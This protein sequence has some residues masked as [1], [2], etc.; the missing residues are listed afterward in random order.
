MYL[1]SS[2]YYAYAIY[3][4]CFFIFHAFISRYSN[5]ITRISNL[6]SWVEL[7]LDAS[8]AHKSGE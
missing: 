5:L 7:L 4:S 3:P 1:A 2:I 6:E 8:H